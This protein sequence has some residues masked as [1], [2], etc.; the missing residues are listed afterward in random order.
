M[1]L[2]RDK[3]HPNPS[4]RGAF[5]LVAHP[6]D[7]RALRLQSIEQVLRRNETS[8]APH[9][10]PHLPCLRISLALSFSQML[11]EFANPPFE[12]TAV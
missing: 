6:R 8:C 1:S 12:S 10:P 11:V 5:V 3:G 7:L 2:I 9:L 4:Q